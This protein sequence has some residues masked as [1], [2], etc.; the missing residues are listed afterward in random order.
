MYAV[1][2]HE[3]LRQCEGLRLP[4]SFVVAS[5]APQGGKHNLNK[6]VEDIPHQ[7]RV[8]D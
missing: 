8:V 6:Y 7:P 4:D 3:S 1:Q 5:T 2:V